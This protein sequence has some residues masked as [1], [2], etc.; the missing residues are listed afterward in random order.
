[1]PEAEIAVSVVVPTR[2]RW[3][4]LST[5]ALP[6]ALGQED[7]TVEVVV[8][9]DG[10]DDETPERL[11]A[12]ADRRLRVVRNEPALGVAGARNAGIEV[13]QGRWVAFLDDDDLWS[14][15]KLRAQIDAAERADCAFTFT[16][17]AGLDADRRFLYVVPPP[18]PET[19]VP[20]LLRWNVIWGGCSNVAA[21][22]DLVRELGGFDPQLRQLSD[23][24]LWIRL[25]LAG[26][27]AAVP[28][29][30]VAYVMHPGSM[31]LTDRRNVF[32]EFEYLVE[33]H[34]SASRERDVE[35]DEALFTRWVAR[36]HRLA[37]RHAEAART[38]LRGFRQHGDLGTV[39]RAIGAFAPGA[40]VEAG[41]RLAAND[42]RSSFRKLAVPEPEWIA[43]FRS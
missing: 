20:A 18:D 19:L 22:M 36:G 33:K 11:A 7:V 14:P 38:Y 10:S 1:L 25:A 34:R 35:F 2:N 29:A 39:P 24:D 5:A 3:P 41:R 21:R 12:V 42:R 37:G 6:S 15:R 30:L 31:L 4:L 26:R 9:D 23:W 43:S 17:M 13:A 40:L 28:D 32:P 8:V 27:S 16:A